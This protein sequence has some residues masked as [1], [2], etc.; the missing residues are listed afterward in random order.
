MRTQAVSRTQ[1]CACNHALLLANLWKS[2]PAMPR[3]ATKRMQSRACNHALLLANFW[4]SHPA[5]PR[6]ATKSPTFSGDADSISAARRV[7]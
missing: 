5:M 4:K 3:G 7:A 2:H 1:S 6:G